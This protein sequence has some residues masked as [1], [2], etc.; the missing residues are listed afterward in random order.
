MPLCIKPTHRCEDSRSNRPTM[1]QELL[2]GQTLWK[3]LYLCKLQL[4]P[5]SGM[6]VLRK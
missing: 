5:T 2:D 4:P 3:Q 1:L 6:C